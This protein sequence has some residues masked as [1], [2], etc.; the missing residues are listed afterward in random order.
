MSHTGMVRQANRMYVVCRVGLTSYGKTF[1]ENRNMKRKIRKP[2]ETYSVSGLFLRI[3]FL[4]L[5]LLFSFIFPCFKFEIA[6]FS[7]HGFEITVF[8]CHGFSGLLALLQK[9][10]TTDVLSVLAGQAICHY[11]F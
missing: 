10:N 7:C 4:V 9:D 2:V 11:M 8:S 5:S 1:E 3:L 6:V